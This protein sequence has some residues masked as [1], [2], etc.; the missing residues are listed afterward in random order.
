MRTASVPVLLLWCFLTVRA[1]H[2]GAFP[3]ASQGFNLIESLSLP[4]R[5]VF[6]SDHEG[7][8]AIVPPSRLIVTNHR[9]AYDYIL[10]TNEELILCHWNSKRSL[11]DKIVIL[12]GLHDWLVRN[13]WEPKADFDD[14]ADRQ[15]WSVVVSLRIQVVDRSS[16][17]LSFHIIH[18][19]TKYNA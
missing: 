5:S 6:R 11:A 19:N 9:G 12:H 13:E 3:F 4:R 17:P 16:D 10:A 7:R 2:I 14:E 1:V 15:I 18:Q 8:V